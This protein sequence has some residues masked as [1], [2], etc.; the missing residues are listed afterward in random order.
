MD[1][2]G[3]FSAILYKG[4]NF[5]DFLIASDQAAFCKDS[6]FFFRGGGGGVQNN[7]DSFLPW[8]SVSS[9]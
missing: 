3:V 4:D 8:M 7:F 6:P 9:P 5:C 1:T 2:L